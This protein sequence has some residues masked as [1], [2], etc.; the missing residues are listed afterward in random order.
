MP[1]DSLVAIFIFS[2][3]ASIGAVVSPG[4]VMAAIVTEAPRQGWRVGP[5]V[6]LGHTLLELVIVVLLGMGLTLGLASPPVRK[7]IAI[8]GGILLIFIGS[9]YLIGTWRG[10][11]RLPQADSSAPERSLLSMILLGVGTT[12]SNPFWYTWWVTVAAGYLAQARQLSL[13]AVG[14]FYIGH[15][16]ADF[17]WDTTLSVATSA[18][19]RFL[20][21]RRYRGLIVLTGIFMLY[22][23][24]EF[25]LSARSI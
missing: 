4:P 12:I 11:I 3:L 15:I 24:I 19:S 23:G 17:A 21:D 14:I 25:L 16:S 20:T 10:H 8:A 18:G 2:F 9:S 6:A 7:V 22:L 1:T 13:L 5:F